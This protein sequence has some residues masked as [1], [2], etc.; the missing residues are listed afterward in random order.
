VDLAAIGH[1]LLDLT[2]MV[3]ANLAMLD[4]VGLPLLDLLRPHRR[5]MGLTVQLHGAG[6]PALALDGCTLAAVP[7]SRLGEFPPMLLRRTHLK[8]L[9]M[10]AST[11]LR[12]DLGMSAAAAA[13]ATATALLRYRGLAT[14]LVAAMTATIA[15]GLRERRTGYGE[16]GNTCGQENPGHEKIS[17][18]R[19]KTSRYCTRSTAQQHCAAF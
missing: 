11:A 5:A 14:L 18:Q 1:P 4:V 15:T 19:A 7:V 9:A 10:L 2:N 13:V 6:M 17:F 16:G 3:V 12:R 8:G